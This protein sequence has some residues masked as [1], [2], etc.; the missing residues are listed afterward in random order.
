MERKARAP[1]KAGRAADKA[2]RGAKLGRVSIDEKWLVEIA[3]PAVSRF[4]GDAD[5]LIH[6]LIRR[7]P[8]SYAPSRDTI[9]EGPKII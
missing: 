9:L 1:A 6:E 7:P 5:Y 8:A 4:K 3:A 2:R